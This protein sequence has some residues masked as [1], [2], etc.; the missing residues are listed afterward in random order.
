MYV[1][2]LASSLFVATSLL[3]PFK[4]LQSGFPVKQNPVAIDIAICA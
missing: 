2:T 4:V 1:R 3:L